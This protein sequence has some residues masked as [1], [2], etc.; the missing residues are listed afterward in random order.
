[1]DDSVAVGFA[2]LGTPVLSYITRMIGT[3]AH[4]SPTL[5]FNELIISNYFGIPDKLLRILLVS[6]TNQAFVQSLKVG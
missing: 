6:L 4:A 5:K 3:I 2:I 1:L